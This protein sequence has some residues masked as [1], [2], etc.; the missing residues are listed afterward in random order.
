MV[1][2][3][4]LRAVV[5][6]TVIAV[7][8][9]GG[10]ALM[11]LAV[12]PV[13]ADK[14]TFETA[15][16]LQDEANFT[17]QA[18]DQ[19]DHYPG[20]Q[21][22]ENGSIQYLADLGTALQTLNQEEGS[23]GNIIVISADWIDYTACTTD[24]TLAFG[25]DRGANLSGINYDED[26]VSHQRKTDFR[27]DGLTV[28]FYNW[29]DFGGDPPYI[30]PEDE[31]VAGQGEGSNGGPC[32][33]Y[34]SEPGWYQ[35]QGFLNGTEADADCREEGNQNCQPPEDREERGGRIDS[36]Y[37][38]ICVCDSEQEAREKLGPPPSERSGT[39]TPT[40]A[41][42]GDGTPTPTS[43]P[44]PADTPTPT[45]EPADT[46]TPTQAGDGGGSS[47]SSGGGSGNDA[48]TAT[49]ASGGSNTGGSNTGGGG[50]DVSTPTISDGP[51]FTS[52]LALVAVLGAALL[53]YRRT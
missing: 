42:S 46:P 21:N 19:T 5:F 20:D 32:L 44:E 6:S 14:H 36:P 17:I 35:M 51:G 28:Y 16:D 13:A 1:E 18:V 41:S 15:P 34:T 25:L 49:Q 24:N 10:G 30:A 40:A 2:R 47:G 45:P 27:S 9:I 11:G 52:P 53:V 37:F 48:A 29:E 31:I 22:E 3:W 12:S 38:Y 23:W 8:V 33:T 4:Q 43:T 50:G 26:L 7:S 39:P